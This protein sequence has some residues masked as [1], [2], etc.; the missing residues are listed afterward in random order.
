MEFDDSRRNPG[1]AS[2]RRLDLPGFDAYAI[3]FYLI[4]ELAEKFEFAVW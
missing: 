1:S 4:I 2:K 3:N